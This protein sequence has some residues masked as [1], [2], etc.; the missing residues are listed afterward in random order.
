MTVTIVTMNVD[1]HDE[2]TMLLILILRNVRDHLELTAMLKVGKGV[3]HLPR[4]LT[5]KSQDMIG[6]LRE[7]GEIGHRRRSESAMKSTVSMDTITMLIGK[8][9]AET[10][11][12]SR[13]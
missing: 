10:Q 9:R 2:T 8:G 4:S 12:T 13:L 11:S 6:I 5:L 1:G 7:A 3:H